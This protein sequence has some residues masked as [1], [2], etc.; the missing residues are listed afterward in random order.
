MTTIKQLLDMSIGQKVGGFELTVKK[1]PSKMVE[2]G[3]KKIQPVTFIDETGEMIGDVLS[4]KYGAIQKGYK[5]HITVG[6]IQN[7]EKGKKLYVEQWWL[8]TMSMA[9]YEAKQFDF[10][11]DMK[12]GEPINIVRGKCKNGL[13]REYRAKNGFGENLPEEV[14]AIMEKDVDYI[15]KDIMTEETDG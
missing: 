13:V 10:Q 5:I 6:I 12:Y 8:P 14:K 1:Y 7:G 2:V 11:Q 9:E 15:L 4:A 3:K